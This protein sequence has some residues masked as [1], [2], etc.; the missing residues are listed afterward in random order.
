[1]A[2]LAAQLGFDPLAWQTVLRAA[3]AIG[4]VFEA[5]LLLTQL[6]RDHPP[7]R[8]AWMTAAALTGPL[9]TAVA[10]VIS[11]FTVGSQTAGR[12]WDAMRLFLR[13]TVVEIAALLVLLGSPQGWP[14]GSLLVLAILAVLWTLR[15]Y[16]RTTSPLKPRA[17][18]TLLALRIV[19][20]LLLAAWAA[21]PRL[22]YSGTENV[23]RVVLVGLDVS[24]SMDR[25]DMPPSYKMQEITPQTRLTPR[26]IAARQALLDQ[27]PQLQQLAEDADVRL[28]TFAG[29]A[30]PTM[31]LQTQMGREAIEQATPAG[32][33]TGIADAVLSAVAQMDQAKR[34]VAAVVILTDGGQNTESPYSLAQL[35]DELSLRKIPLHTIGVG[36]N[37][38]TASTRSLRVEQLAAPDQIDVFNRLPIAAS[39]EA[40]G[41]KG[42]QVEVVCRFANEPIDRRVLDIADDRDRLQVSFEHVPLQPGFHR[43]AVSAAV[44]GDPVENL[45][46][47]PPASQLV[48]V[49]DRKTRILYIEG[50]VRYESKFI[51]AAIAAGERFSLDRRV[52]LQPWRPDPGN[53]LSLQPDDWL[54][55]HAIILGSVPADRFAQQ[56]LD[57]IRSLVDE[58]GKGLAMI[59]GAESFA[60]GGWADTPLADLLGV[61]MAASRGQITQPVT[62]TPTRMGLTSGLL[63]IDPARAAGPA[64]AAMGPL[65][66]ANRI[67]PAATGQVLA[68]SQRDEPM[69]VASRFGSGRGLAI[70]FDTT[71]RWVLT[72]DDTAEQQK[73][74]WRQ[75]ALYLAAPKGN[76]WI[77]TDRTTYDLSRLADRSEAVQV[78]AGVEDSSGRPI[79]SPQ[80]LT[81]TL[82]DPA[83]VTQTL[84][85]A[86]DDLVLRTKLGQLAQA[87]TY[88]LSISA[89]V[90]DKPLQAQHRFEVIRRDLESQQVLADYDLLRKLSGATGGRFEPLHGIEPLLEQ[91]KPESLPRLE[92]VFRVEPLWLNLAWPVTVLA[93]LLL[94]GEW[95]L[96]KRKGLV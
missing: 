74:F 41:L 31:L 35:T 51:A 68:V 24:A 53:G 94:C 11:I 25:K 38:V 70:A 47:Q 57:I 65:P 75:V 28:F 79:P 67:V 54:M 92:Q 20:I 5:A 87:G 60:A 50:K 33:T 63:M 89:I 6:W 73:R 12:A 49:V 40:I 21:K 23:R 4:L 62:V 77:T 84:Q 42:R 37:T 64:W 61:D 95:A 52:L 96:R 30:S 16:R 10:G 69:I 8:A 36:W 58:K 34:D 85:P 82:T 90:E 44:L 7:A 26:L 27:W 72:P 32:P 2:V 59:G 45:Q 93:I 71:W 19:A 29:S 88:V 22:E 1:M 56:Q 80:G 86:R 83:G 14:N 17:K 15:S 3:A 18:A 66:G 46:T 76:I 81:V 91:I 78:T 48:H 39:V 55:Y 43:L 9:A 13:A